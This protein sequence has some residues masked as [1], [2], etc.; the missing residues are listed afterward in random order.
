MKFK[1]FISFL[2]VFCFACPN[3][4]AQT[5]ARAENSPQLQTLVNRAA[6]ET[7]ARFADKNLK[8]ESLAITLIDL[9]DPA[10]P[11]Q[12]DF[13]GEQQIY[14]ASVVKLFYLAAAHRWLA[15][16]KTRDTPELR[17]ALSDMIVDSSNDA[18]HYIVDVLTDATGGGEL[19]PKELEG[20]AFK[21]NAV[22]RYF[23][24]L[25]F[26]NINVNQKTYCEDLYGRER[27]FWN[28]GKLRN[29]LTTNATAR[30]LAEIALGKFVS[31]EHSKQMLE[32]L[33]RDQ[34]K[35][36]ADSDNQDTGFTGIAL[37]K[38]NIKLWSKAGWT[39]KSRH[40]AAY[41]ETPEG[42][43]FVLVTFTENVAKERE[44]VPNIARIVLEEMGK[45]K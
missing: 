23:S 18:T 28:E 29:R 7:L 4:Q 31:P 8:T 39:S 33:K 22:N 6:N 26:Q 27:Q 14:P 36:T 1:I 9:R 2:F 5:K 13:R 19:A 21:R 24:S 35:E 10:N 38:A 43:K 12:A 44:I 42:L 20:W 3:A 30:L 40:D 11:K 25:G 15:D 41:V 32:L 16:G 45:T 37:K 17:R 34:S